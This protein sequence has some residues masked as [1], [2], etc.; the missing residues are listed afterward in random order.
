MEYIAVMEQNEG[1][2][3]GRIKETPAANRQQRAPEDLRVDLAEAF[4]NT[5]RFH[6]Q[7]K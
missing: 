6:R 2:R 7:K 5:P 1:W 3:I 4:R